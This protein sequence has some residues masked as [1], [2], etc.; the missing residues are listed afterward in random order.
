M[1]RVSAVAGLA[2]L[3]DRQLSVAS[4]RQLLSLGMKDTAMQY[5]VRQGGPWQTLLPGIY[6]TTSGLPSFA[7]KEMAA[8]LYAGPGSLITGPVA[9][10]HHCIRSNGNLNVIDMLVPVDRQRLST[11]FVRLHRTARIPTRTC[12]AGPVRLAPAPRAVA[13]TARLLTDMRDVRAVVAEAVQL[14]RC[15]VTELAGELGDAPIRGSAMLRSVLA[16]VADGVRSTAE[17]D[18]RTLIKAARLP[19]PLFNPSLYVGDVFLGKPDAWWSR[20]GVA[21]EVDSRAW[22]LSPEDW[23]RTRRRH[24]QMAAAGI[25]V[26]HFSPRELRR[27]PAMVT[28][29]IRDALAKG[30]ARPPL[31]IRTTPIR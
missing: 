19:A 4:R 28:Q 6:L 25:I 26:L 20:A 8:L 13:D 27:E 10:M 30:L 15:T 2:G 14:G 24:D 29:R 18:L 12:S 31:P 23:D 11:G 16:E 5:R 7:Q 3:L 22:H 1:P 17:G 21:V 9:L